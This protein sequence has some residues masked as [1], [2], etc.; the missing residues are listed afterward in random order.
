MTKYACLC[1]GYL[2]LR[3]CPPGSFDICPV[4]A[5]EDDYAQGI[6]ID[7][8]GGANRLSL[9]EARDNFQLIGV[10]DPNELGNT[11]AAHEYE[12]PN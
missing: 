3:E 6:D 10:S 7:M 9:S 11:R 1:C 5:W 4:C 8:R 12:I 2:T